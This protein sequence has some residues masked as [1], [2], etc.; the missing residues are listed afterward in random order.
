MK[1]VRRNLSIALRLRFQSPVRITV[2]KAAIGVCTNEY[3]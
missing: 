3:G 2:A 1:E